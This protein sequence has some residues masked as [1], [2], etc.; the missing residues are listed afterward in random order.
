[1]RRAFDRLRRRRRGDGLTPQPVI[2]DKVDRKEKRKKRR[3]KIVE[4]LVGLAAMFTGAAFGTGWI[5]PAIAIGA[6]AVLL[7]GGAIMWRKWA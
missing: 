1:M 2:T 5:G 7:T 6:L 4:R 3:K